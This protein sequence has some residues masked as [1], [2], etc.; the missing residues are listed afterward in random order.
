[1]KNNQ[2]HKKVFDF[3]ATL[4]PKQKA[5]VAIKILELFNNPRPADSIQL[6]GH[7]KG[8]FRADI[9]EYRIVYTFI[10]DKIQIDLVG[11]RNDGEVYR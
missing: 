11:K 9:G 3:L 10:N 5:Q 7:E 6:K 4:P 2:I 8:Y 1:M